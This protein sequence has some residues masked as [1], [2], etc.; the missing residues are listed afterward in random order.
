MEHPSLSVLPPL[1][2]VAV[3]DIDEPAYVEEL[4]LLIDRSRHRLS[5]LR[6]GIAE[7]AYMSAWLLCG[8]E[9]DGSTSWPRADGVLGILT[10]RHLDNKQD[11]AIIAS[12]D[13]DK[14]LSSESA[15][16]K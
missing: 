9:S 2:N 13:D 11:N 14:S 7:K 6:I 3:L 4:A 5:E 8:K 15:I 1:K 10:R 16:S 12:P